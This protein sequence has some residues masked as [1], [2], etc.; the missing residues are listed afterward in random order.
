MNRIIDFFD[1]YVT[2][3]SYN[4]ECNYYYYPDIVQFGVWT[5]SCRKTSKAKLCDKEWNEKT[6]FE[7]LE[8]L[9]AP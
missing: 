4:I 7:Q 6:S 1:G 8:D 2:F 9:D 5:I 3:I